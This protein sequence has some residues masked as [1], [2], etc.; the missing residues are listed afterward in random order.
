MHSIFAILLISILAIFFE[1]ADAKP[2]GK[3]KSTVEIIRDNYGVPHVY[4]KNTYGLYFGFGYSIATDRLFE[5]EMARRTVLGTVAE[6]LGSD[7]IAFDK[8]IRSNYTPS[9]IQQQYDKL[10]KKQKEIFE[11]EVSR[12]L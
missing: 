10:S 3:D 11:A 12:F 6:V 7:Y 8:S 1:N 4:A 9:S 2:W 5:M